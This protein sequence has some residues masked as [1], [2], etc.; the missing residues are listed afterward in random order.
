MKV[1]VTGATGYLGRQVCEV[2]REKSFE[3]TAVSRSPQNESEFT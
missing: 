3:F 1:L 2:L